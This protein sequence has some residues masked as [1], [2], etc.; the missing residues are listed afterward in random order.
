MDARGLQPC[1][2]AHFLEV[3]TRADAP[4]LSWDEF[5]AVTIPSFLKTGLSL[6]SPS[7]VV[8]SLT[9]SSLSTTVSPFLEWM[10]MGRISFLN[11]PSLA[12]LAAFRWDSMESLSA[13]SLV[14]LNL[15]ATISPVNPMCWLLKMSQSPSWTMEST[16]VWSFIL[17]PHLAPGMR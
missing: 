3:T 1:S 7:M 14:T 13:S 12:A 10:V 5:P 2:S 16:T 6:P 15:S 4:S 8:S 17:Y 11:L 9:P